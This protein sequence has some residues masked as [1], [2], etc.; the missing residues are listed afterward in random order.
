VIDDGS[1]D[2]TA[3][4]AERAIG[5]DPR[6]SVMRLDR[7]RGIADSLNAGLGR[8]SASLVA[9]Q[10]ADDF[11]E[12]Q[13]LARQL[14]VLEGDESVAVVGARMR[15]IDPS[16][17]E[18]RPR[19]SFTAGDVGRALMRFNPIPNGCA[20]FRVEAVRSAGGYDPRYRFAPEYDLWIRLAERYRIVALDEVLA[21]RV[22]GPGSVAARAERAQTAEAIAI[23]LRAMRRRRSLRGIEGLLRPSASYLT[24]LPAKRALRR[25]RGQAP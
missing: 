4:E 14:E 19:T 9:I 11:S 7:N 16:G 20:A 24:P 13:R 17:R 22:M 2:S 1:S 18:L 21:T 10:D 3:E 23:R 12:P 5:G 6:G 15:E 25:L 8:A